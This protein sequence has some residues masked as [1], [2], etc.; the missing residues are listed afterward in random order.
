MRRLARTTFAPDR[1]ASIP[2]HNTCTLRSKIA[3]MKQDLG[4]ASTSWA[5]LGKPR[6]ILAFLGK[7]LLGRGVTPRTT[8]TYPTGLWVVL[9]PCLMLDPLFRLFQTLVVLCAYPQPS[10]LFHPRQQPS[11]RTRFASKTHANNKRLAP[12]VGSSKSAPLAF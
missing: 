7:P 2:T 1:N 3:D 12:C 6:L 10:A 9:F 4:Y 8:L 5:A 11:M